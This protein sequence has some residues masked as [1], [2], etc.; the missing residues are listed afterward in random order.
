[1]LAI[2]LLVASLGVGV[3]QWALV[4]R[5]VGFFV[6]VGYAA[7]PALVTLI[8][9]ERG[10]IILADTFVIA[11]LVICAVQLVAYATH[12]FITPLPLDFFGYL[13]S[14]GQ[15]LEGY[16][17]NPNAFAFQL[18]V[19]VSVLIAFHPP[20]LRRA[21]WW[22]LAAAALLAT[23]AI[24]R[25]R[26]G[27]VCGLAT[28]MLAIAL[29]FRPRRIALTR[30]S[31]AVSAIV[32]T[33]LIA[34]AIAS[35]GTVDHMIITPLRS[36]VRPDTGDSDAQRWE[37]IVLGFR[38]W[39]EH[40]VFGNGLGSFLLKR[41]VAGSPSLVIHSVP[42]WFLAEMGV[43]GLAAYTFFVASL[44]YYGLSAW[45]RQEAPARG[46]LI[47]LV[48]F[49]LMGLVHDIFFQRTFWFATSLMLLSVMGR[50][51]G[52]SRTAPPAI[53]KSG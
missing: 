40:P 21:P 23:V 36:A 41:D 24:I 35:W 43:V 49:I 48:I 8:A 52:M 33:C 4:N 27:I 10:R 9:G 29:R 14:K 16:A 20:E 37:S 11:A 7:V 44:S 46:L 32:L 12:L 28:I 19:A 18:L 39:L 34:L 13:F 45:L 53:R 22:F 17:Q 38:A 50:S 26:A 6:L 30:K 25:S 47:V 15:E 2:G 5:V 3:T 42:V 1:M 51:N 31:V